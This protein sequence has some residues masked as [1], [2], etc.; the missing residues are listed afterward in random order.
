MAGQTQVRP[1]RVLRLRPPPSAPS[2]AG[3]AVSAR[4]WGV[5]ARA[6]G[7]CTH[8]GVFAKSTARVH[9]PPRT[10]APGPGAGSRRRGC[11]ATRAGS[12]SLLRAGGWTSFLA[13]RAEGAL[14]RGGRGERVAQLRGRFREL[15]A[16]WDTLAGSAPDRPPGQSGPGHRGLVHCSHAGQRNERSPSLPGSAKVNWKTAAERS[17][18]PLPQRRSPGWGGGGGSSP[19]LTLGEAG[20]RAASAAPP[21]PS[22][23]PPSPRFHAAF[24]CFESA[25]SAQRLFPGRPGSDGG[26]GHWLA[27]PAPHLA[28]TLPRVHPPIFPS[29]RV[30]THETRPHLPD[31]K[32]KHGIGGGS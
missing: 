20:S 12:S 17:L 2:A 32:G 27:G 4:P 22:S 24:L 15:C 11:G 13:R 14:G 16:F 19:G 25:S 18:L 8:K 6:R 10:G 3:W 21:P 31:I 7:V 29:L 1:E 28:R 23:P 30:S 26:V 5:C 9:P